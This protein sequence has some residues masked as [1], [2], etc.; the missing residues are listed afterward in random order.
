MKSGTKNPIAKSL[1]SPHLHQRVVA[2]KKA[3]KRKG[4]YGKPSDPSSF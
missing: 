3:Y 2:S 4:R 1:R